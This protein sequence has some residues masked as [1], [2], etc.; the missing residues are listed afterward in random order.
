[1][2]NATFIVVLVSLVLQGWMLRW[3]ARRLQLLVLPRHGPLERVELELPGSVHHELVVYHIVNESPVARGARLPPRWARPSWWCARAPARRAQR[4]GCGRTTTCTSSRRRGRW[5]CSIAC[6]RARPSSTSTTAS[7]SGISCCRSALRWPRSATL[8]ASSPRKGT[9]TSA[10]ASGWRGVRRGGRA[11]RP[12]GLRPDRPRRARAGRRRPDRERRPAP[13]AGAALRERVPQR[14]AP[15]RLV[16][17]LRG[18]P[19]AGAATRRARSAG[20]ADPPA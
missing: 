11:R 4:G 16:A 18:E 14:R 5:R 17:A 12:S 3:A 13:G 19:W 15:A 20:G 10:S 1:M 6:S 9:G 7:C 2:F 8:T